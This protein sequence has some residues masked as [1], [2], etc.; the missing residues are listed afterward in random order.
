MLKSAPRHVSNVTAILG[1]V[2]QLVCKIL[3]EGISQIDGVQFFVCSSL[4]RTNYGDIVN[5]CT[6]NNLDQSLL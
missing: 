5:V 6:V 2:F 1:E 4:R 3:S